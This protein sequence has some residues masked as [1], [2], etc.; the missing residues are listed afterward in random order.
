MRIEKD[1]VVV[2]TEK[3]ILCGECEVTCPVNAI[4][5]KTE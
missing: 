5:L 4:K 3:C 1:E 2:D